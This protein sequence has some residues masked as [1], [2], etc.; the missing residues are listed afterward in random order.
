MHAHA[1]AAQSKPVASALA[2]LSKPVAAAD[3]RA[4]SGCAWAS[5]RVGRGG[6]VRESGECVRERG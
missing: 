4:F 6:H 1:T 3:E 5:A 2:S